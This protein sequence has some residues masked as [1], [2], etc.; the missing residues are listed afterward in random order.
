MNWSVFKYRAMAIVLFVAIMAPVM[1]VAHW[2]AYD[3][4]PMW[5]ITHLLCLGVGFAIGTELATR[6][7]LA[8]ARNDGWRYEGPPGDGFEK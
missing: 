1:L 4:L 8:R 7:M 3:V 5:A 2:L 6:E